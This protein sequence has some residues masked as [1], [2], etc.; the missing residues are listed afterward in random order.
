ME[1]FLHTKYNSSFPDRDNFTPKLTSPKLTSP[2]QRDSVVMK[3]YNNIIL[4][5]AHTMLNLFLV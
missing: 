4:F 2:K 1:V 3:N 5:I